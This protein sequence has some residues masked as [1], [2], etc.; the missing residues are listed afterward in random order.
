MRYWLNPLNNEKPLKMRSHS[1]RKIY[2]RFKSA[3]REV[4]NILRTA[5]GALS[6]RR[7]RRRGKTPPKRVNERSRGKRAKKKKKNKGKGRPR[8]R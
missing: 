5:I 8:R 6:P 4:G 3:S 7:R 2:E 1:L